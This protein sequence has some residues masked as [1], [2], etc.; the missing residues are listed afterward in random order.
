MPIAQFIIE[1]ELIF[2][3]LAVGSVMGPRNV[4]MMGQRQALN[5][6]LYCSHHGNCKS[7]L[8]LEFPPT[9][10]AYPILEASGSL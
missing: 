6:S 1:P 8:L 2:S 10:C 4:T 5:L 7:I 9:L 3:S